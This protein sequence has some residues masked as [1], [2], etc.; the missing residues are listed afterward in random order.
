MPSP[1]ALGPAPTPT[2]PSLT[3]SQRRVLTAVAQTDAPVTLAAL[4]TRL[5]GHPNTTR[6]Q[7]EALVAEGLLTANP[8]PAAQRGRPAHCYSLTA[9]GR[10]AATG[11]ASSAY[12]HLVGAIADHLAASG[13]T[14]EETRAIGRAWKSASI[15]TDS[16]D[17]WQGLRELLEDLG[18]EPEPDPDGRPVL[19]LRA[20]PVLA[21]ARKRPEIICQLHQGL[22]DATLAPPGRPVDTNVRLIPFA[23]TG[24][25]LV[26]RS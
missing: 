15:G 1:D 16:P 23:E 7:L 24:A 19:R 5:G 25:C 11:D 8:L 18:F 10:R 12:T 26:M 3:V 21:A 14:A 4:A 20:C 2:P 9:L 6:Q 13:L 17:A 22:I